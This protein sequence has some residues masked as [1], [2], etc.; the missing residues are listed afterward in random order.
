MMGLSKDTSSDPPQLP[1][2]AADLD[3]P[4]PQPK[5]N[6]PPFVAGSTQMP[7]D[8]IPTKTLVLVLG[9]A[10]TVAAGISTAVFAFKGKTANKDANNLH[11]EAESKYGA[12]AC[13]DATSA[14]AICSR[15]K[16]SFND[17][18]SA[19]NIANWSLAITGV[20]ATATFAT[21]LLWPENHKPTS[22]VRFLPVVGQ[23]VNGFVVDGHF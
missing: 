12:N 4:Q 18:E 23:N 10:V 14:S 16:S 11:D 15:M 2:T 19:N 6:E 5:T 20:A 1:Y 22:S 17:R 8:E 7:N 9:G 13:R 21:S 3:R